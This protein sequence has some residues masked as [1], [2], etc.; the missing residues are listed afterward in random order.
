MQRQTS[1]NPTDAPWTP[2]LVRDFSASL[3]MDRNVSASAQNLA[4]NSL[5]MFFRLMF[6]KEL[7]Y[8]LL[9]GRRYTVAELK[10][11]RLNKTPGFLVF[12]LGAEADRR[13]VTRIHNSWMIVSRLCCSYKGHQLIL[14]TAEK[15]PDGKNEISR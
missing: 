1:A 12:P 15:I 4:F 3:A 11:Q 13:S 2:D 14:S 6:N 7:G 10:L 8:L 9:Y 5:L